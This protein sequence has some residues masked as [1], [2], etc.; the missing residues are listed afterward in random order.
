MHKERDEQVGEAAASPAQWGDVD[1]SALVDEPARPERL[2]KFFL[3][4]ALYRTR[5]PRQWRRYLPRLRPILIAQRPRER[6][7]RRVARTVGSRG[8]PDP[9]P[10]P[11][12][13][14]QEATRAIGDLFAL[15]REVLDPDAF[16][17]WLSVLTIRVAHEQGHFTDWEA[18]P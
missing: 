8:D 12:T 3:N 10:E 5:G 6:R 17:V 4:R 14:L 16:A 18:R 7:V 11:L 9:E 13:P 1:E 2:R 15:A